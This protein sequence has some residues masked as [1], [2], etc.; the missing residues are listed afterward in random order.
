MDAKII[1]AAVTKLVRSPYLAMLG[2]AAADARFDG[3]ERP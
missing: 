3:A 1:A 2:R